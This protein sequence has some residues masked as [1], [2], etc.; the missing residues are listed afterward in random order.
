MRRL[1]KFPLIGK[2]LKAKR[3]LKEAKEWNKWTKEI[4]DEAKEELTLTHSKAQK[5]MNNL[6]EV[7]FLI[8]KNSILPFVKTFKK[9]KNI[10]FK[11]KKILVKY[12]N[13]KVKK[14]NFIRN[15]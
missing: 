9:V 1:E 7:K 3:H 4:C 6:G 12:N 8:Y 14:D 5:A 13:L 15:F 10:N 2:F 11:D